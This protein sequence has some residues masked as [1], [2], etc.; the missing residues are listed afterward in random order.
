MIEYNSTNYTNNWVATISQQKIL[1]CIGNIAFGAIFL[2]LNLKILFANS[3]AIHILDWKNTEFLEKNILSCLSKTTEEKLSPIL[4]KLSSCNR[5][6]NEKVDIP[7]K[8]EN[9]QSQLY[10]FLNSFLDESQTN[11]EGIIITIQQNFGA[12]YSPHHIKFKFIQNISHE[13]RSPLFNIQS[14]LETILDYY[15][16]LSRNEKVELLHLANQEVFRLSRLVNRTANFNQLNSKREYQMQNVDIVSIAQQLINLYQF[17]AH[18]KNIYLSLELENSC[19]IKGNYDLLF[20]VIANLVDNAMKFTK[21]SGKIVIRIFEYKPTKQ[22]SPKFFKNINSNTFIRTEIS[23]NGIGI[24]MS[25]TAYSLENILLPTNTLLS[26]PS[27]G[28]GLT[29]VQD[30][31]S[32]HCSKIYVKSESNVGTSFWF[33]LNLFNL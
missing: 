33:D 32:K 13:F 24:N 22:I 15:D 29:I 16:D 25:K 26:F 17:S 31:I 1:N 12:D 30:I 21:K 18:S 28:L 5:P 10:F 4:T 3:M 19:S 9:N 20:Q 2:D 7:A 23:D 6:L 8:D 27:V 14:V 11:I